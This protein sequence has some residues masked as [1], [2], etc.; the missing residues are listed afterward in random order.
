[1]ELTELN[2]KNL[3]ILNRTQSKWIIELTNRKNSYQPHHHHQPLSFKLHIQASSAQKSTS[4]LSK[5][6]L[7]T[8]CFALKFAVQGVVRIWFARS[9]F[10]AVGVEGTGWMFGRFE[11]DLCSQLGIYGDGAA[12]LLHRIENF[13]RL[14]V[15]AVIIMK[16]VLALRIAVLW[17][18]WS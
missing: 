2:K 18:R 14:A 16:V 9:D 17:L 15:A 12:Y 11:A 5:R 3:K 1:M 8:A 4:S 6:Q 7:E 10:F 13:G